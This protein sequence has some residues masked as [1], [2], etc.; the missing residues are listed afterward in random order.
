[1]LAA[2]TASSVT[3]YPWG[4]TPPQS[5]W[6]PSMQVSLWLTGLTHPGGGMK[7]KGREGR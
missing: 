5:P 7:A 1:M 6:N 4:T 2:M 3:E